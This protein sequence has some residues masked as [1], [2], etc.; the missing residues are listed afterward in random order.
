MA[1]VELACGAPSP[2]PPSPAGRPPPPPSERG[3]MAPGKL[4]MAPHD[5]GVAALTFPHAEPPPAGEAAEVAPGVFWIRM[6][7]PFVLNHINLWLLDDGPGWT[8]VDTGIKSDDTKAT[9]ETLFRDALGGRPVTRVLVTHFHPDH[10][11]LAG[12]LCRRW[13]APLWTSEG[14][15]LWARHLSLDT[16][17][18][19]FAAEQASFYRRTGIDEAAI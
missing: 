6:R 12:W 18:P 10:M 14:E 9:W 15:W 16:D 19:S 8:V 1:A 17:D 2:P 13:S 5:G 3:G 7:L 11:G 4:D